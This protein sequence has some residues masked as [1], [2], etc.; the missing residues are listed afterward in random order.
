MHACISILEIEISN[1]LIY[2]NKMGFFVWCVFINTLEKE[3]HK[4]SKKFVYSF[5]KDFLQTALE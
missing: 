4:I 1:N 3:I 2:V 5:R